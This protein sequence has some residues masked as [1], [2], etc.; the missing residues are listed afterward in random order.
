M[1]RSNDIL[2]S[3]QHHVIAEQYISISQMSLI[4]HL[5]K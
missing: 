3:Y 2:M 5:R 4:D 1:A